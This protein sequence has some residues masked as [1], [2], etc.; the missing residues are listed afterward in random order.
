MEC[1]KLNLASCYF[2]RLEVLGDALD[3]ERQL[4]VF[5]GGSV[6]FGDEDESEVI[7]D[8]AQG[9]ARRSATGSRPGQ[10]TA[11]RPRR[12]QAG[13]ADHLRTDAHQRV[14]GT[15]FRI[16]ARHYDALAFEDD[17]GL[18]VA[19]SSSPLGPGGP[20]AH[21]LVGVPADRRIDARGWAFDRVGRRA[22]P[23]SL[24]HTNFPDA[25]IC[26]FTKDDKAW[27]AEDGL[28]AL[29]DHYS[30]WVIKKW[31]RDF[32]GW[33]PGPQAGACA[34]Y[35]RREFKPNEWCGCGSGKRYAACHQ[36]L[37]LLADEEAGRVEFRRLF[38]SDYEDRHT[39]ASIMNAALTRWKE[40]PTLTEAFSLRPILIDRTPP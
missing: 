2:S 40:V 19:V 5:D 20:Q 24:K 12:R 26:A 27:S 1:G 28:T 22:T 25:S 29:L 38:L 36:A 35:R 37:D 8:V 11:S 7:Q 39:P 21:F 3:R 9:Q 14:F 6:G 18:W 31:H 17:R 10:R 16:L 23:M 15:D 13:Q 4:Y 30:I 34:T 33:W 32:V